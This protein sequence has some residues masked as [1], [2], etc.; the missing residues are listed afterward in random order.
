M[1]TLQFLIHPDEYWWGGRVYDALQLPF[2]A[3]S[4]FHAEL[5]D[6][7]SNQASPV[8]LSNQGRYLWSDN[9]FVL[10][11]EGGRVLCEGEAPIQLFEGYE[12]LRGAFLAAR[13]KFF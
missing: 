6:N 13:Q 3:T 5:H 10:H 9:P 1:S 12:T 4:T 2:G 11:A 7:A 8:Y